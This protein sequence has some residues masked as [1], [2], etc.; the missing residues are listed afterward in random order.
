MQGQPDFAQVQ[1]PAVLFF[2][3]AKKRTKRNPL[4]YNEYQVTI[5]FERT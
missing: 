2:D 5:K 4:K 1:N 3:R